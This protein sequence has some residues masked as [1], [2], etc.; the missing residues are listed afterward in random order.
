MS[1]DTYIADED[2]PVLMLLTL[3]PLY[4]KMTKPTDAEC[5]A[6]MN[7]VEV[8]VPGAIPEMAISGAHWSFK[9]RAMLARIKYVP[10]REHCLSINRLP[11][12]FE[13]VSHF[14]IIKKQL[15]T[16]ML[17]DVAEA[18]SAWADLNPEA[19]DSPNRD[20][21]IGKSMSYLEKETNVE[22]SASSQMKVWG[23]W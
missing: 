7:S 1:V 9:M 2:L 18:L 20:E 8:Y 16:Q 4:T 12:D 19:C 17:H 5:S 14:E 23:S 21:Y 6:F 13:S 11:D 15:S 3:P 10:K 22:E